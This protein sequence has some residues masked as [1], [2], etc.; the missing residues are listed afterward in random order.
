V[1]KGIDNS[2]DVQVAERRITYDLEQL[3]ESAVDTSK[4]DYAVCTGVQIHS[5][6]NPETGYPAIEFVMP[7][8][9][10]V[11]IDGKRTDI[12]LDAVPALSPRQLS[13]LSTGALKEV[14]PEDQLMNAYLQARLCCCACVFGLGKDILLSELLK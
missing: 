7:T 11:V 14:H 2:R 4:A 5:W 1:K 9:A 10:Y 13:L 12:R 6:P 3:I 8:K